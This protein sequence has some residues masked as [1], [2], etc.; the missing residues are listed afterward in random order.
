M[1]DAELGRRYTVTERF[2]DADDNPI[3]SGLTVTATIYGPLSNTAALYGPG[4]PSHQGD[5]VYAYAIP[6]ATTVTPGMHK[7]VYSTSGSL[8]ITSYTKHF[9]VGIKQP[10]ML[11]LRELFTRLCLLLDD[12]KTG[13][14]TGGST[15]TIVDSSKAL[16]SNSN[17]KGTEVLVWQ[18]GSA[19]PLPPIPALVT[20]FTAASGTFTIAPAQ[21]GSTNGLQ[22]L[23]TN[24]NGRGWPVERKIAALQT[25]YQ[26][27]RPLLMASDRLTLT[28]VSNQVEYAVPVQF[29]TLARVYRQP[30]STV[31]PTEWE[32]IGRN[33]Y[34]VERDRRLVAFDPSLGLD[35]LN[36]RIRV[37]GRIAPPFPLLTQSWAEA[38]GEWLL[39]RARFEL[40]VSSPKTEHQ[41][42]AGALYQELA[43]TPS[44]RARLLP[45]EVALL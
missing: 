32:E 4:T 14:A 6:D 38:P 3:T 19:L 15:T 36:W 25:A 16:G 44:P 21:A 40:L 28:S 23:L 43:R 30:T 29:A 7:V 35:E 18:A 22:Y 45:G 31:R 39:K 5:G 8:A 10:W 26:E 34:T 17:W 12:G 42:Q 24:I 2:V 27:A 13:T 20:G 33:Y 41:R 1:A 37:D 11:T 9:W